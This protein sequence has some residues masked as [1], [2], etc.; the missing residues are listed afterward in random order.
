M[1]KL[2]TISLAVFIF[3][4]VAAGA[5]WC[6]SMDAT[7]DCK[8]DMED[9]AV[10]ASQWLQEGIAAPDVVGM[11]WA[12]AETAI[13]DVDLTVGTVSVGY[14]NTVPAGN[15]SSQTPNAG[16]TL[17]SGGAVNLVVSRGPTPF[18]TTWDTSLGA[19][20]TVTL[21]LAGD[22]DAEI[23]W[24]DGTAET[25]TTG[26]PY[27]HDYGVDGT[28]TVLV[29]GSVETY[30]SY[31]N[32]GGDSECAKLVSVDNWGHLGF[33]S[34]FYAFYQ[35]SNLVSLPDTSEGI[36]AVTDMRGMFW[37]ASSFNH[38]IGGWDISSVTRMWGMFGGALSFNQN[39]GSWD[40]SSVIDMSYMFYYASSFNHDIDGWNTSSVTDMSRMFYYASA[41]NQ[42]LSEWCVE[43]ITSGS[44]EFDVG[45]TSWTEPR[46]VWGTCP[47]PFETTWDTSL[48]AGTTVTLALA[49]EVD[50]EIDWGDG[51]AETVTTGGPYVHDYGVDGIY[52]V[53]V[54]GSVGAYNSD[55]SGGAIS[56]RE[57][58]VSV[59]D[60]GSLDFTSM[61]SAFYNC[62]NL[63]S[64]PDT[65]EGIE[66]V[67]DMS[68][69]FYHASS[70]NQ[71]I[72]GWYTSS[73]TDMSWMFWDASSF[74]QDI[75]WW[76]TSSVTNMDYM[77]YHASSF[78]QDLSGWSVTLIPSEPDY[79][80][81]DATSWTLPDSRPIWGTCPSPFETTWDTSLGVGTTV[82]LALNGDVDAKIDWGDGTA[83]IVTSSDLYVHDYGVD[84][85]Y[86]VLVTGSVEE[87]NSGGAVSEREKLISVDSWGQLGFTGMERAFSDCSN[88]V[89]VPDTSEGIEAVTDMRW[90]FYKASSFNSDI[91]NWDT[92]SAIKM[93]SMF[94]YASSFNQDIGGWDTSSVT[95]MAEMFDH[96][97]SFNQNIGG[98]DTS[99][100]ADMG[101]MFWGADSF[102]QDIG[103]WDTSSVT[104][105]ASMFYEASLFNQDIGG[106]DTS[107]VTEMD[108]MFDRASSFNQ[109]LSG[110]CV[111]YFSSMPS[112]FDDDADSWT[113]PR[114]VWGTCPP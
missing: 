106:W 2:L 88:L 107:S 105:M 57:K 103:S 54:T 79:F 31:G 68:F 73:V 51:T 53:L 66:A 100:V 10:F 32:G 81:D 93:E 56:E 59:D 86:T 46:P 101:W 8:V 45:A 61:H 74:N 80:D 38:D 112:S 89:S 87:Y 41:F 36:E 58:L 23:D 96:A 99:N 60:W 6:P 77:F 104:I 75:G 42:D 114:P 95:D 29:T 33:T 39:I 98:W 47:S 52:T 109:D 24:G 48:G 14:S 40:T 110:W 92:S 22:V 70:F 90:M 111:T 13:T 17:Q 34:M 102:N 20:T 82:T 37:D 16:E 30:N 4:G 26:G 12:A 63:V 69:M 113:L 78:N 35:C 1:K 44:Y 64:V 91:G 21:A 5:G 65:S 62:S 43:L 19:G 7:G 49:G 108:E 50:A 72:G 55:D 9:F 83:E 15:I 25:V 85:T 3:G 76:D 67:T 84:G 18:E 94:E 71:D 27:V 97:S 28:Y 11:S